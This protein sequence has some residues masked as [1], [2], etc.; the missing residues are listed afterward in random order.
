MTRPL[1][2]QRLRNMNMR[3]RRHRY[4]SAAASAFHLLR[5]AATQCRRHRNQQRQLLQTASASHRHYALR[6]T[7]TSWFIVHCHRVR[8]RNS[9]ASSSSHFRRVVITRVVSC[10]RACA[11]HSRLLRAFAAAAAAVCTAMLMAKAVGGWL[12]LRGEWREKRQR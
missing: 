11:R 8:K 9:F 7:F 12:Q 1:Q 6:S 10:M 3:A 5:T 4:L 2:V